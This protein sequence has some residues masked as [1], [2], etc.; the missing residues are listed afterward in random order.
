MTTRWIYDCFVHIHVYMISLQLSIFTVIK[1]SFHVLLIVGEGKNKETRYQNPPPP[2]KNLQN[3]KNHMRGPALCK[4]YIGVGYIA[5]WL[6]L[7]K[8]AGANLLIIFYGRPK[9]L[10]S[11]S[12]LLEASTMM[13]G[14]RI[15][16]AIVACIRF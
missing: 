4:Y 3:K 2:K 10:A 1:L 8:F 11:F 6:S 14:T 5:S 7:L 15:T 13:K 16:E 9:I 12:S